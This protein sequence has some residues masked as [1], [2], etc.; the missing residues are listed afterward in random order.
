MK[1]YTGYIYIYTFPSGKVYIGQT[2]RDPK[3]RHRRH[4]SPITGPL[5]RR[6]WKEYQESGTPEFAI[7][8][9]IVREDVDELIA[10]LN[11]LE[12]NYIRLYKSDMPEYG[13]NVRSFGT[14]HNHH[15]DTMHIIIKKIFGNI[16]AQIY[17]EKKQIFDSICN[18]I[19]N[20]GEGL[21]DEEEAFIKDYQEYSEL[22]FNVS[23]YLSQ[24][25]SS[26]KDFLYEQ[27]YELLKFFIEIKS[28]EEAQDFLN[29]NYEELIRSYQEDNAICQIDKDGNVIRE[30][31]TL[32]EICEVF[33]KKR[34]DNV[35]NVLC[36]KQKTAY[37][38]YWK[39]KKDM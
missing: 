4:M 36:G 14:E 24:S 22:T 2:R 1:T 17:D 12:S 28:Q 25:T 5:N 23:Y 32:D 3:I 37:G 20:T 18:K 16:Y 26:K 7:L 10:E 27:D 19:T 38:F 21:N 31:L 9:K 13:C 6:F 8:N 34:P 35:L 33:H 15:I 11:L 39:R 30:F 29:D